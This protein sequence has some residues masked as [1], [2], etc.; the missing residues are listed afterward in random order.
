MLPQIRRRGTAEI[1]NYAESSHCKRLLSPV[2]EIPHR[3]L[4]SPIQRFETMLRSSP[5]SAPPDIGGA[6]VGQL[7]WR[8]GAAG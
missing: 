4:G 3:A 8:A 6:V 2:W 7:L 1:S 5:M